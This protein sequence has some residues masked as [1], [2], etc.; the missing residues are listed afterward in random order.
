MIP[1][2]TQFWRAI[3]ERDP[4]GLISVFVEV[5]QV[6][7]LVPRDERSSVGVS[8][9]HSACTHPLTDLIFAQ[10]DGPVQPQRESIR[11]IPDLRRLNLNTTQS[12]YISVNIPTVAS[13]PSQ[14]TARRSCQRGRPLQPAPRVP[15]FTHVS[16]GSCYRSSSTSH[17]V[18]TS[19][20][21]CTTRK[22]PTGRSLLP[23]PLPRSRIGRKDRR[24]ARDIDTDDSEALLGD[25]VHAKRTG[26]ISWADPGA[27]GFR[28]QHRYVHCFK[29]FAAPSNAT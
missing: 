12:K 28:R 27:H 7:H 13:T 10:P 21:R 14:K 15:S 20:P 25:I 3:G 11:A 2:P 6:A 9:T 16:T 17:A 5:M 26:L 23:V 24:R 18:E 8:N 22:Q 1:A 29:S 19:G 4:E